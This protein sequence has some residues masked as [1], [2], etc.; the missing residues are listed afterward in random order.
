[1]KGD[2]FRWS[3]LSV[4]SLED[5]FGRRFSYLRLSITDACNFKCSYCLPDGYQRSG[6]SAGPLDPSEISRLIRA[7]VQM[8]TRKVR[9]TGGE[10]TLRRDLLAAQAR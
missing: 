5:S 6:E 1:M 4:Q 7:F 3:I 9:L 2:H 8:G 10:P